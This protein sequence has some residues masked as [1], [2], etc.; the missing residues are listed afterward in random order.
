MGKGTGMGDIWLL[1]NER[2]VVLSSLSF[3]GNISVRSFDDAWLSKATYIVGG[4]K[5]SL[6]S[7]RDLR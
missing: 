6:D 7:K 4:E 3:T 2:C 5:G 1:N